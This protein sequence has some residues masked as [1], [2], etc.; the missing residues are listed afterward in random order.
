MA[1]ASGAD[2]CVLLPVCNEE[3]SIVAVVA[4]L[5]ATLAAIPT[6]TRVALLVVDDYSTDAG[7]TRLKDWFGQQRSPGVSLM[8]IRLPRRHGMSMALL[9]GFKLA[10]QWSP[11]LT[12]VMDADGQDDPAFIAEMV[13]RAAATEIVFAL[14][15][16]RSESLLF[17]F[18]Y[19]SFQ[20]L[21]RIGSGQA[22]LANQFCIMRLPVLTHVASLN[23][24]DYLGALLNASSF[25]RDTLLAA[26]RPRRAG[27]S[28]YNWRGHFTT[29]L[30]IMS[31]QPR[32][33]IRLHRAVLLL[34]ALL[35]VAALSS[36]NVIVI[37]LLL[38]VTVAQQ[39]CWA[40]MSAILSSRAGCLPLVLT[41]RVEE[42]NDASKT[43]RVS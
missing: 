29:A 23:Y 9:K 28:K 37:A 8:L 20:L 42:V 1:Q 7:I 17:R 10:V 35:G 16:K 12:L 41:E 39:L 19:A 30:T 34:L 13:E 25:S 26:R 33:L 22:A 38:L 2:L 31:W 43:M 18:C 15:G 32:F 14:R 27:Q 40:K 24:I 36:A 6:L 21:M 11:R 3:E 5:L 4:E